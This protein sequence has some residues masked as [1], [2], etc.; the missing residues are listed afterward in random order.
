MKGAAHFLSIFLL[1]SFISISLIPADTEELKTD[2]APAKS[3]VRIGAKPP[4]LI[5]FINDG[6][7]W[8]MDTDGR[9]RRMIS[10]VKN[11][12]GKLSFSP[13]NKIIAYSREGKDVNSLPS[14]EGGVH[15]LHDIFLAYPDSAVTRPNWWKRLTFDLGSYYPEWSSDGKYIYCQKDINAPYVDYIVPSHQLARVEVSSSNTEYLRSDWQVNKVMMMMPTITSDG[16]KAAFVIRYSTEKDTYNYQN[17][18]IKILPMDSISVNEKELRI[19]TEG[20]RTTHAPSWSPDGQWL[21]YVYNDI[22][23]PGLYIIKSDLSEKRQIFVP[24]II[25][26]QPK[27]QPVGWSPNSKWIVFAASDGVIFTVDINGENLTAI[28]GPGPYSNPEW[29]N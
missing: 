13:D 18:G 1:I 8:M 29:S 17:I 12:K 14:G 26:Q 16:K 25:S 22:R 4:G 9:N 6:D 27:S 23:N 3:E 2:I 7:I 5:A 19:P 20:L 15:L 24:P 21:A 10:D 11:A 28:T